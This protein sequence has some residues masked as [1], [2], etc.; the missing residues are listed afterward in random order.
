MFS[1]HC[2]AFL[3]NERVSV[4]TVHTLIY[5]IRRYGIRLYWHR[6]VIACSRIGTFIVL[7]AVFKLH[8]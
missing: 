7:L 8:V 6:L 5:Y 1:N 3:E 2:A 4:D